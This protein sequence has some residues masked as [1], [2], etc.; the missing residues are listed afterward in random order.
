[1]YP[2][3]QAQQVD[4]GTLLNS[5]AEMMEQNQQN[6]NDVDTG[7]RGGTHGD[8]IA[9]AF[10]TAANAAQ[11]AGT[12]DAGEQ[13]EVAA[14]AMR[15]HGQGRAVG[16][17]ADGLEEAAHQ[18]RGQSGISLDSIGPFLE[19]FV[20]GVERN[21][22]AKPG[23][24]TMVDALEPA[25][26]ALHNNRS[27]NPVGSILEALSGAVTGAR[28]T[29][30]NGRVDPGAASA[31][32]FIGGIVQALLPGLLS[33]I[34]SRGLGGLMR[35]GQRQPQAPTM[36]QGDTG[37]GGLGDILGDILGG[38]QSQPQMPSTPQRNVPSQGGSGGLDD[39]LGQ[40]MGGGQRSAPGSSGGGILGNLD[41]DDILGN[42]GGNRQT[43]QPGKQ[44]GEPSWWPF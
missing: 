2:T 32:S 6:L 33:A 25:V 31:T 34:M 1:M 36:P 19:S 41:L 14:Q 24:G 22:P 38:G 35:G 44:G 15:E 8:R 43:T 9:A 16:Y 29:A 26:S 21:N 27:G 42:L 17:Y 13:L 10:R 7:Q 28:G 5:I 23:Q 20:H 18:F 30:T 4:V 40:I 12:H 11:N 39:L 37:G 3:Q